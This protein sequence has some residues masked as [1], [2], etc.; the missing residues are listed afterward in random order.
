MDER[1]EALLDQLGLAKTESEIKRLELKLKILQ[2][3]A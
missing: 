2:Q 3:Q 1:I